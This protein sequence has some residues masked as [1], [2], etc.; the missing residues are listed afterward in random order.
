MSFPFGFARTRGFLAMDV[1]A[2]VDSAGTGLVDRE[3]EHATVRALIADADD[4]SVAAVVCDSHENSM[5]D[6][7][8]IGWG[9]SSRNR[10][11]PAAASMRVMSASGAV[12]GAA[13][14]MDPY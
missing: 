1:D 3:R 5:T 10:S 9:M 8:L 12:F 11:A 6:V 2:V 4:R 14:R 7:G 13:N